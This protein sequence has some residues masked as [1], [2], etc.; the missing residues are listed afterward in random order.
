MEAEPNECCV[1]YEVIND[2]DRYHECTNPTNVKNP[3]KVCEECYHK[4]QQGYEFEEGILDPRALQNIPRLNQDGSPMRDARGNPIMMNTEELIAFYKTQKH[5]THDTG[6]PMKDG[7]LVEKIMGQPVNFKMMGHPVKFKMMGHPADAMGGIQFRNDDDFDY[8]FYSRQALDP[9][10]RS[11]AS[12]GAAAW[13]GSRDDDDYDLSQAIEQS[14]QSHASSDAAARRGYSDEDDYDLSQAI[15]QS[16]QS[17]TS[18]GAAARRSFLQNPPHPLADRTF[19]PPPYPYDMYQRVLGKVE[20][21]LTEL[22][23]IY[24]Q[25][26]M[27]EL[28]KPTVRT[29]LEQQPNEDRAVS[30]TID[31]LLQINDKN[32]HP[33]HSRG[34]KKSRMSK[35]RGGKKFKMTKSRGGKKFKMTKS[36]RG[37]KSKMTRKKV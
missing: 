29:A 27:E 31:G 22:G 11:P 36:R 30:I 23:I 18:S 13:R 8:D 1:C 14:L 24:P 17:H 20:R 34:G 26:V 2:R 33:L 5:A 28:I 10:L 6:C 19:R 4:L 16:L 35:S 25:I 21:Q 15:E 37:R 32:R 7:Q 12:S 3:H 9:S